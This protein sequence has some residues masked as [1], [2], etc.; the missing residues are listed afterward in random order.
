MIKF[1][2]GLNLPN[3]LT[4]LRIA[5]I[6]FFFLFLLLPGIPGCAGTATVSRLLA[7]LFF[8][9]ASITDFLDGKIARKYNLITELGKFLDPIA[10]KLMVF[11]AFFGLLCLERGDPLFTILLATAALLTLAREFAVTGLRTMANAKAGG[12]I[13]P[14]SWLGKWKTVT[15]I[16][17]VLL[18][19]LEPLLWQALGRTGDIFAALGVF[20]PLT[21]AAML[22]M[23]VLTVISGVNYFRLYVPRRSE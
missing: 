1:L 14:A 3:K 2:K 8:I 22:A 12:R 7:A 5:I 13:I 10:D 6:P 21:Y 18:A 4:L 9:I 15:Q 16:A 17:F 19:L 20:R 23:T 11:A